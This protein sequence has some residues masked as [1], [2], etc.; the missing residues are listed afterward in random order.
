MSDVLSKDEIS[1]YKELLEIDFAFFSKEFLKIIEPETEFIWNWHLDVLCQACEDVY[2]GK[3]P[4]LDINMPP[5]MLK[6]LI[7]NVLFPVWVW[8]KKPSEKFL[9]ASGNYDL[10]TGFNIKRRDLIS[11][12]LYQLFWPIKLREDK[13]RTDSFSNTEGG[14]MH[15][16]S[17][18]GKITGVGGDYLLSDDLLDAMDSFS[19]T[20]RDAVR[21]WY[22]SAFYNR[23]QDKKTVK[24]ININQRLHQQD[25]SADLRDKGFDRLVLEMVKTNSNESTIK[26][27]D[28][29]QEGE[30]LFPERYG[31]KEAEDD[32]KALGSYGWSSQYQQRPTPEGGGIIKKE[33]LRFYDGRAPSGRSIIV[34]DLTFKGNEKSDFVSFMCWTLS[35]Q[36][37]YLVDL[38]RGRWSYLETKDRFRMFCEKNNF[39]QIKYI[40][41]KASGPALISDLKDEIKG[42]RAWPEKGSKYMN[43]GK[44]ERLYLVQPD[45]EMGSVYLPKDLE[46]MDAYLEE[47]LGFTE[48]GSTTGNDDMVDTTAM[49]LLELKKTKTFFQS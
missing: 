41:D 31:K 16:V 49:G 42:I 6:S 9:C 21:R 10:A 18:L 5:R 25:I 17:A 43:A 34:A 11:S 2:N 45:F 37:K 1:I 32:K 29:R 15:A 3:Y 36:D 8:T 33:W 46:I 38:V 39:A 35:G 19:R 24:R 30:F 48:N 4:K 22:S 47:L 26:Y 20:K 40:E 13:N 23:A 27:N 44:V 12:D 28:P 7:V 14:I